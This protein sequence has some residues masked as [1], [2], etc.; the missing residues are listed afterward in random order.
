VAYAVIEDIASSWEQYE[1]V[2]SLLV[3]PV[4]DGLLLHLAGPTDEGFRI[5]DIWESE[6]ACER[7]RSGRVEPALS[8]LSGSARPPQRV[9][10]LRATHVVVGASPK[11]ARE[12]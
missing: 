8:S 11:A 10:D 4:P 3:D 2:V 9:R 1:R 7:F 5:I 6:L 12:R